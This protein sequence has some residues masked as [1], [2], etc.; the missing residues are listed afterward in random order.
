MLRTTYFASLTVVVWLLPLS[1]PFLFRSDTDIY[2]QLQ[3]RRKEWTDSIIQTLTTRQKIGQ[4]FMVAAYSSREETHYKDLEALVKNYD[5]GGVIFFQGGPVRQANI[6]NRLQKIAKIPLLIAI[7]AEWGLGM[8]LD[9][10]ISFPK[11][12]TLGAIQN[13]SL[14]Y[15]M[16]TT[17]ARHCKRLGIHIN[18]APV[19]DINSNPKNPVIGD[20]AFSEDKHEVAH[21]CLLYMNGLQNNGIMANAKHFPGHGD[22]DTDSHYTLPI[23][24]HTAARLDSIELYPFKYLINKGLQSIMISHLHIPTY[25]NTP[26]RATTL[27]KA[28]ATDLLQNKLGFQ[29]LIFTDALN[30]KGVSAFF[31]HSEIALM[32][33]LAGNDILLFPE[34]IP[35]S[36]KVIENALQNKTISQDYLDAKVRKILFAKYDLG[37][38]K[39]QYI[40]IEN[41]VKDL[42]TPEDQIL[43]YQLFEKAVTLVRNEKNILPFQ[44]LD[45]T[46][47]FASVVFGADQY[48]EFQAMLSN[49]ARFTHFQADLSP[50]KSRLDSIFRQVKDK[51]YVVIGLHNLSNKKEQFGISPQVL[52]WID[53]LQTQTTLIINI[54]GSA[55]SLQ[56]FP[57]ATHLVCAYQDNALLRG[58]VPQMLF[59]AVRFQGKLPV[60]ASKIYHKGIGLQTLEL[61]RLKYGI[62]AQVNM[63]APTLAQID[64]LMQKAIQDTTLAGGQV[65]I[66]RKG[67]VVWQK[68]YGN[69]FYSFDK[70]PHQA[71]V[72]NQT[73]YDVASITKI[74]ATLPAIMFLVE[75]DSI[76]LDQKIS[77][78]LPELAKTNKKNIT[79][80]QLL[81]HQAGLKPFINFWKA[82]MPHNQWDRKKYAS[83]KSKEFNLPLAP[84]LFGNQLVTQHIHKV[85]LQS[86]LLEKPPRDSLFKPEYS[87][88]GFYLLQ[89]IAERKLGKKLATFVEQ[90]LAIPLG[91]S[92][93]TYNPQPNKFPLTQIAPTELDTYFRKQLIH[94]YVHDHLAAMQGGIGGHAGIFSNANDI[95]KYLQ[96]ILQQGN[97]GNQTFFLP[98]TLQTFQTAQTQYNNKRG[99]GWDKPPS[100]VIAKQAS[101]NSFG[102][103]GFTG[104]LA[105]ADAEQDLIF[106]FLS[107]RIH[108]SVQNKKMI[109]QNLRPQLH[110]IAYKAILDVQRGN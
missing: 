13:D 49:Y 15:T 89:Q 44:Q 101:P 35:N 32:A 94:G 102:H 36:I 46:T 88:I 72:H 83:Q 59:G 60:T 37:L 26:N 80:R 7:D 84:N 68:S 1:V 106:V 86:A 65:L 42:N 55:Y 76:Q 79:I 61:N 31:K 27:S 29:G 56:Y 24:H 99:L 62:P 52:A 108:P 23:I 96:M 64:T 97:Y 9:S 100:K 57:K 14:I 107:N 12:M 21:K 18:F 2:F 3:N 6:T 53:S 109:E 41:L 63:H 47:T 66:A 67:V 73:L 8:R 77:H 104:C 48:N 20:R 91:M 71:P 16:A 95:A 87:D 93:L 25:D 74:V 38:H 103:T 17:I 81:A 51:K 105:W 54:F 58:L 30:M 75:K 90:Y 50:K 98:H 33:F 43:Q 5:I 28:V 39:K 10:T 82:T 34:D 70:H 78:Y 110:E 40:Q 4:L 69:L 85:V 11:Q 45:S 19:A 22:T 92:T